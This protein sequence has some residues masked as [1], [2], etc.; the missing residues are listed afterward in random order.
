MTIRR[1]AAFVTAIVLVAACSSSSSKGATPT[2]VGNSGGTAT[3]SPTQ[4]P[5]TNANGVV[6][7]GSNTPLTSGT[8]YAVAN[9]ALQAS[10]EFTASDV[11]KQAFITPGFFGIAA[12]TNGAEPLAA[13]IDLANSRVFRDPHVDFT[14]FANAGDVLNATDPVPAEFLTFLAH[15]PGMTV[16]VP[17]STTFLGVPA[18]SVTYKVDSVDGGFQCGSDNPAPCLLVLFV[19]TGPTI[20]LHTGD[21]GT[22]YALQVSGRRLLV[23][24]TDHAGATDLLKTFTF[25]A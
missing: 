11:S 21:S 25:G 6:T 10:I 5:V 9:T 17:S 15:L 4:P 18:T 12:D 24:V 20:A 7:I 14:K 2:T 8:K 3:V 19:T 1:S 22:L 16:G 13:F 23:E